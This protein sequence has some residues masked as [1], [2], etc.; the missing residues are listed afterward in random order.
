M[1][2]PSP[3]AGDTWET[4]RVNELWHLLTDWIGELEIWVES[5]M[6]S[7]WIYPS[8]FLLSLVDGVFPVVPSESVVI[9]T[10]TAWKQTGTPWVWLVWIFAAAGAWCG[11]QLAY[12]LGSKFDVRKHP[13]FARAG[14]RKTLD[15]AESTLER[16]GTT[17]IIAARF[18]PMGRVAVNLTAGALGYPRQWFMIVDAVAAVIWATYG[19]AL[20]IWAGSIFDNLLVSITVGVVGGVVMGILIDKILARLG[21][22]E[23]E[24]PDL[25]AQIEERLLTGELEVRPTRRERRAQDGG[26]AERD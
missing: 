6:E 8:V 11:D 14:M 21:F 9:A 10:A 18:I 17:F 20:G 25:S 2:P 24:M 19:T 16:R 4:E 26:D 23:P 15:W 3:E 5:L 22:A 7:L 1:V 13:F 12:L